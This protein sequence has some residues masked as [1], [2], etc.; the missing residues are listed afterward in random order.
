[1]WATILMHC[2]HTKAWQVWMSLHKC[3]LGKTE[4]FLHPAMTLDW[5][6]I[7]GFTNQNVSM[8]PWGL[9]R[10]RKG[11][12]LVDGGGRGSWESKQDVR[13]QHTCHLRPPNICLQV[14]KLR[15]NKFIEFFFC[16]PHPHYWCSAINC[17][18]VAI[19]HKYMPYVCEKMAAV[20][21]SCVV[22][23]H[24]LQSSGS[25]SEGAVVQQSEKFMGAFSEMGRTDHSV[26]QFRFINAPLC[27]LA[28]VCMLPCMTG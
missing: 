10:E 19:L 7:A 1:M 28:C 11:W 2:V 27:S 15:E 3:W 14:H 6:L 4:A 13:D 5:T 8:K 26:L 18:I 9:Y 17:S 12:R 22:L 16:S 21:R 20:E 23:R 25:V 24:N